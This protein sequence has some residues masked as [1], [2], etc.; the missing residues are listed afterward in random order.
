MPSE[1]W[2]VCGKMCRL[3][4]IPFDERKGNLARHIRCFFDNLFKKL[5]S[6]FFTSHLGNMYFNTQIFFAAHLLV[7]Q[8]ELLGVHS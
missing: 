6:D 5:D 1:M 2:I 3:L 8:S 4:W 7:L